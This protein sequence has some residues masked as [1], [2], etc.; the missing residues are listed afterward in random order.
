[1][2]I[3]SYQELI[4]W[5]KAMDLAKEIYFLVKKLPKMEMFSLSDQ[6][7]RAVVS[8]PSNIAEGQARNST[9][10]LIRFSAIANGSK[11]ELETQLLL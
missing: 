1:M 3:K 7:R 8:I 9:K 4:V 10:E 11:A 2:G 6:M 5:Q